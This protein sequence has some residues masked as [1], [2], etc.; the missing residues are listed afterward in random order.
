MNGLGDSLT[1]GILLTLI[2]G[3][4][5]FY[6]YSRL[7]QN[8]KRV[9][10]LENLLLTLKM[11][12]EASLGGP[13]SVEAV[14]SPAPITNEDM[15]GVD[16]DAYADLLKEMPT[17]PSVPLAPVPEDEED[18]ASEATASSR[19]TAEASPKQ[20]AQEAPRQM[21]V[22]YE[23]MT[24]KELT[25]LAKQRGINGVQPRKAELISALKRQGAAPSA[26]QPL[27]EEN[28]FADASAASGFNV[29][30]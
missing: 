26:P 28:D 18:D 12:T 3:A 1:I 2:F 8:E 15:E 17:A 5:S 29:D 25:A 27:P 23:S 7:T 11:S 24:V 4:V 6:L 22:S 9:S 20:E 14:S 21:E 13:D 16:E 19:R 30:L 10:L